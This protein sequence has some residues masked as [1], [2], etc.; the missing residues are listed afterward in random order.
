MFL[1]LV[2]LLVFGIISTLI[3]STRVSSAITKSKQVTYMSLD[4]CFSQYAKEVF[5]DYGIMMLWESEEDLLSNYSNYVEKNTNYCEGQLDNAMDILG[6]RID[7]S[8]LDNIIYAT[9]NNAGN[10]ENQIYDYMKAKIPA[11]TIEEMISSS[12]TLSQS[13]RINKIFDQI[14]KC[15]ESF[16]NIENTVK[17]INDTF[18]H[19]NDVNKL[20]KDYIVKMQEKLE[21]ISQEIGVTENNTK[22]NNYF[23]DYKEIYRNYQMSKLEYNKIISQ[24]VNLSGQ[25]E[26]Y[27]S[28]A[29][30]KF[31]ELKLDINSNYSFFDNDIFTI[32][33]DELENID[34]EI[35]NQE[36]DFYNV[37]HNKSEIEKIKA[38]I[39]RIEKDNLDIEK[40][41]QSI[42]DENM[43]LSQYANR[44]DFINNSKEYLTTISEFINNSQTGLMDVKVKYSEIEKQDN[45][46]VEF[47]DNL[48]KNG[49]LG[50]VTNSKISDKKV[51]LKEK[52]SKITNKTKNESQSVVDYNAR[53]VLVGEYVFDKFNYYTNKKSES[54]LDYE[55]E[56]I[57]SGNSND[58]NNLEDVSNKILLVREGFNLIYLLKDNVKRGEAYTLAASIVG[59]TGMPAIIRITQ[60]IILGAWAYAESLVDVKDLLR[61]N[62]VKLIKT[63]QDW[64]LSLTGIYNMESK[65]N[66]NNSG[67]NY[68][69]YL[70][71]FLFTQD[72]ETLILR[73]LDL[74]EMNVNSK[75]NSDFRIS[76]SIVGITINSEYQ[77][78]TLFTSFI[79]I[80]QML[81]DK[82]DR[83]KLYVKQKYSY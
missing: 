62:K 69:D 45:S 59:I 44:C 32:V 83:Y 78:K 75:Y 37:L 13:D 70:R 56:Y 17:S 68:Q 34:L 81:K 25:Y 73:I 23:S 54:P 31:D 36:K 38:Q 2:L 63:E 67:L 82:R 11:E 71:Y 64:N 60:Y 29:K 49:I 65:N 41:T 28:S 50:Y 15:T 77:V 20:Q 74:I 55:A 8:K 43:D 48:R 35:V 80:E 52:P 9:D 40:D 66:K 16:K 5:E 26:N 22:I 39:S 7:N 51:E 24:I 33:K 21:E 53:K 61:G 46:L 6:L 72:K 58:Q 14:N 76:K 1:A 42:I 12:K 4:S 30:K 47:V 3:E 18:I 79:Y 27:A 10:I 57:I 19:L